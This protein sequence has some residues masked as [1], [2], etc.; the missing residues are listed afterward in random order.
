MRPTVALPTAPPQEAGDGEG[1]GDTNSRGTFE[2][3]R[4]KVKKKRREKWGVETSKE[5]NEF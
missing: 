3:G 2:K 4:E 1:D 5:I